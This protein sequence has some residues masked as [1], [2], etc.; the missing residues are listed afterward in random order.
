DLTVR[1]LDIRT[2]AE[3][4]RLD[5]E[6]ALAASAGGRFLATLPVV[7]RDLGPLRLWDLSRAGRPRR[8]TLPDGFDGQ[9]VAFSPDERARAGARGG[10]APLLDTA[11]CLP[12]GSFPIQTRRIQS[13]AFSSD[14]RL[15]VSSDGD[16]ALVWD[17][18]G[19]LEDGKLRTA[20]A[21]RSA[22]EAHWRDLASKDATK[23]RRAVWA[24]A[25]IGRPAVVRLG[26]MQPRATA[27][28]RRIARL[29]ADLG[30]EQY[31][32]RED[33]F[34]ELQLIGEEARSALESLATR[35]TDLELRRR[36]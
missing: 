35:K 1:F 29:L 26:Q 3:T 33:A 30:C 23:A 21:D 16:T 32:R 5:Q 24:L 14:G 19:R 28:E 2:G 31:Q 10:E 13:L 4:G 20:A 25:S 15:L 27:G 9:V 12:L 18:T 34:A 17:V 8:L 7:R 36:V 11:T 6:E 22:L